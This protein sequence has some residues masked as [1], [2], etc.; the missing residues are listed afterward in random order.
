MTTETK[1]RQDSFGRLVPEDAIKDID[2][3]RDDTVREIVAQGL[4][5]QEQMKAW[6]HQVLADIAAFCDVSAEQYG[7]KW[8]GKK[9]NI[10]LVSF[11]GKYKVLLAVS[12]ALA[13]D[14]RLQVAKSLIDEC[15][16]EWAQNSST[17]IKVLVEHAFQTDKQGN[18]NTGRIFGLMR[19]KIDHPKWR[20]AMEALKDSIQVTATSQYLRLYERVGDS[21]KYQQIALDIAGV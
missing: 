11:D 5:L 6:K 13:F 20:Q 7:V 3:L 2:K 15:I 8:G 19:V 4:R 16:H 9:G 14:E 12:D 21:E 18:I 17:E 1:Y 10:A